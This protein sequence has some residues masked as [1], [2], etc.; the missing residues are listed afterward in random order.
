MDLGRPTHHHP[1][2]FDSPNHWRSTLVEYPDQWLALWGVYR[3]HGG[4]GFDMVT[5]VS[6]GWSVWTDRCL[7]ER[8]IGYLVTAILVR[9]RLE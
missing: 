4:F 5:P 9:I 1:A 7:Y 3:S 6:P 2:G 8:R